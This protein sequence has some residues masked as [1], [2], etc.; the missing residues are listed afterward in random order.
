MKGYRPDIDGIRAL[1]VLAVAF[2]HAG[3]PY[4]S[5]G[6]VGVDIFFVISGYLITKTIADDIQNGCFSIAN[7]Y[8]RRFARILPSF[9]LVA[10]T[11]WVV[12]AYILFKDEMVDLAKD[13][14]GSAFFVINIFLNRQAGDYFHSAFDVKPMLHTWSLSVEEQFYLFWPLILMFL[15]GTKARAT[16]WWIAG[17]AS[18]SFVCACL[19]IYLHHAKEAFF[20]IPYRAW[21]LLVGGLVAVGSWRL[22]SIPKWKQEVLSASGLLLVLTPI[23]FYSRQT[24][25]PGAAALFP[26]MGAAFLICA[27][28]G[29][30]FISRKLFSARILVFIGTISYAFYLWHWPLFAFTRVLNI[31]ELPLSWGMGCL[32]IAFLLAAFSTRYMERPIRQAISDRILKNDRSVIYLLPFILS[33]IFVFS[34][35]RFVRENQDYLGVNIPE[36]PTAKL[37]APSPCHVDV[38]ETKFQRKDTCPS[39]GGDELF[40]WGDSHAGH[41]AL[42]LQEYLYR[43][44]NNMSVTVAAIG[45]CPPFPGVERID[46]NR[47]C[48]KTAQTIYDNIVSDKNIKIVALAARFV[49]YAKSEPFGKTNLSLPIKL[50]DLHARNYSSQEELVLANIELLAQR[51]IDSGKKVLILGEVP[52]HPVDVFKCSARGYLSNRENLGCSVPTQTHI[53]RFGAI[54]SRMAA[55]AQKHPGACFFSPTPSLCSGDTCLTMRD[56][57]I[58]YSDDN[59]LNSSGA[60]FLSSVMNVRDCL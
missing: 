16:V 30:S 51:L 26:V 12:G 15:Y 54:E 18:T 49:S 46:D 34:L 48:A 4:I 36:L 60:E 55:F 53:S 38:V 29:S 45:G 5:G 23:L 8:L 31:G 20:L 27:G 57:K 58:L 33:I 52:T 41:Y 24:V 2:Y 13:I 11:T 3:I 56:G 47:N 43:T 14:E 40:V 50:I 28:E 32:A 19:A 25:F 7:F 10:L 35:G 17:I 21:E 44:K 37:L 59:H 6:F 42:A 1:A 22:A 39:S 9:V